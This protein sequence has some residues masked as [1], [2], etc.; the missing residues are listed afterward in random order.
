MN[1]EAIGLIETKGLVGA[2]EAADAMVKAANVKLISK[3]YVGSGYAAVIVSGDVGAVKAAVDS[4]SAAA[5]RGGEIISV[6][7]IPR[8]HEDLDK[9]LSGKMVRSGRGTVPKSRTPK[10]KKASKAGG[11]KKNKK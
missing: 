1:G 9:M 8:P 2:T 6:H 4:G 10:P 7:V 3:A 5:K 11:Q